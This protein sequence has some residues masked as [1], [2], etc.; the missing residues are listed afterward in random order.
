MRRWPEA[1][2]LPPGD[3][4][5]WRFVTVEADRAEPV[6]QGIVLFYP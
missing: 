2:G 3:V 5:E 1:R 6:G 4:F